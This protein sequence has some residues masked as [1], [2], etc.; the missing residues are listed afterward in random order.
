VIISAV[1]WITTKDNRQFEIP[2]HRHGDAFYIVSQ[3]CSADEIDKTKTKQG[4]IDH[5]GQFLD[6]MEARCHAFACGQ[7]KSP[8]GPL[9]SE[10]LW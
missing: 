7:V 5:S 6:R 3:F 2:C 9:C 1:V 4:F 10:D 8:L